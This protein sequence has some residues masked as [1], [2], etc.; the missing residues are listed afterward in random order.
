MSITRLYYSGSIETG[1]TIRL[2]KNA[3][4][5]LVKVMRAKKDT[6][7]ILFNGDSF[8]YTATLLD[9]NTKGCSVAVSNK[10]ATLRESHLRITLI[11]G[12]SRS[13]RMDT[14]IQKSI[15]LGVNVIVPVICERTTMKLKDNRAD[16]KLAHWQKIIVSACEQSGRCVIPQ[17]QPITNYL[18]ALQ[19]PGPNCKLVLD[20][21][22]KTSLKHITA[23]KEDIVIVVGPE[24]GLTLAEI[25]QAYALNFKGI[26]LGPRI[27]RTE[28]AA[29]AC[30][31]SMQTLWGDF[32][33]ILS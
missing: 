25:T 3:S 11:Q 18:Q 30:I 10:T 12:I 9:E 5:H 1:A 16:K 26:Q 15:E 24:G 2:E 33:K 13:D 27:L 17:L 4:H 31:A 8:E 23:P 32:G 29:P 21:Q 14:C 7:V 6:S 28:T 22:S 19:E 20:P